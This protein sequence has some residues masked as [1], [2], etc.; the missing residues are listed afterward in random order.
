MDELYDLDKNRE[1]NPPDRSK[2]LEDLLVALG[3]MTELTKFIF[4]KLCASG[5]SHDDALALTPQILS[6]AYQFGKQ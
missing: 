2:Q 3:S 1:Q 5:F 6:I 4:D